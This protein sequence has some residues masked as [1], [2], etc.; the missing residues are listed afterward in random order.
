MSDVDSVGSSILSIVK[1]RL[2]LFDQC[3]IQCPSMKMNPWWMRDDE[4]DED[5]DVEAL[6]HA[7]P[8][9]LPT[10]L[11]TSLGYHQ[12]PPPRFPPKMVL[13]CTLV[14]LLPRA[15]LNRHPL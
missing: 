1:R 4:E 15:R 5:E 2:S 6:L 8:Y 13:S 12:I 7:F 3:Q 10:R 11:F 9:P 14:L